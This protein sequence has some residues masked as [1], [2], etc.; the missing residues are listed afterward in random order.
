MPKRNAEMAGRILDEARK[1]VRQGG[2]DKLTFD[3]IAA[4]VGVSK[5][6]VVYWFPNKASLVE[7]LV[8]PALEAEDAAGRA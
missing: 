8:R 1:L 7:A 4:R 3:A 2:P 5:Q 6:A